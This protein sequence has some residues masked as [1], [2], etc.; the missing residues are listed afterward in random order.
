MNKS[1]LVLCLLAVT[2]ILTSCGSLSIQKNLN[3]QQIG[4]EGTESI[5]HINYTNWG[6]YAFKWAIISGSNDDIGSPV[7][8][9]NTVTP[10]ETAA[11]LTRESKALGGSKAD[12]LYTWY[13]SMGFIIYIHDVTGSTNSLK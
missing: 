6:V 4:P 10:A 8:F 5:A 1:I 2:L 11:V 7:W 13:T 9:K 3:D 12:D